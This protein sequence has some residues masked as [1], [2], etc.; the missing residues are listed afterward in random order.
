MHNF[1]HLV[2]VEMNKKWF[3]SIK[4]QKTSSAEAELVWFIGLSIWYYRDPH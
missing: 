3:L 4:K 1:Y 2:L